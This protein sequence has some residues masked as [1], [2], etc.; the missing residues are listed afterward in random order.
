MGGEAD[1]VLVLRPFST[2]WCSAILAHIILSEK[3][4]V[5]GIMGCILCITGSICI[6]LHAPEEKE[7]TSVLQVWSMAMQPGACSPPPLALPCL[8]LRES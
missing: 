4:N 8:A 3:L 6:V 1:R 7:V 5:F 2:R